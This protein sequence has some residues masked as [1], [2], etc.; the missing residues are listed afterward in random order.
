MSSLQIYRHVVQE[1]VEAARQLSGISLSTT[2]TYPN[3]V[4]KAYAETGNVDVSALEEFTITQF[5]IT[6]RPRLRYVLRLANDLRQGCEHQLH[7][8]IVESITTLN[9]S[10]AI[11]LTIY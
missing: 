11:M 4:W 6:H 5:P 2:Q 3:S 9:P 1:E 8:E 10:N 7:D